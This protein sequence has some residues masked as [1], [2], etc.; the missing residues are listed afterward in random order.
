MK[1]DRR[2]VL[3]ARRI[4]SRQKELG[5]DLHTIGPRK[6]NLLRFDQDIGRKIFGDGVVG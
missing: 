5:M 2:G 6:N 3:S 4:F 1:E